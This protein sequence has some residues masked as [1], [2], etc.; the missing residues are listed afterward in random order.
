MPPPKYSPKPNGEP[1]RC[2]SSR[3]KV[4][5]AMI[6]FGRNSSFSAGRST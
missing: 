2:F 1:K 6:V 4:S 3:K 5:S